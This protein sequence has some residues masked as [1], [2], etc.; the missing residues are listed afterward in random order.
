MTFKLGTFEAAARRFAGFVTGD[1]TVDL[2]AA[3][4][5]FAESSYGRQGRLTDATSVL[6]LLQDWDRNFAA[7]QRFAEFVGSEGFASSR[8]KG[9]VHSVEGLKVLPPVIRP[10]KMLYAAANY[11]EHVAGMR[12]TFRGGLPAVEPDKDYQGDKAKS[13]PYLFLKAGTCLA[14]PYDNIVLPAGSDK[15][16]WEAELA[17]VIGRPG[18]HIP[19]AKALDHVAGYMTTNDV[20]CRSRTWRADRPGLR[21]D[22]LG[23]KSYDTFAPMGPFLVPRAFVPDHTKLRIQ[24]LVNGISKQDGVSGDMVFGVEEQIEYASHMLTLEAGDVFATGTPAGTGQERL[25]YL[26]PGDVV[27]TEV[28]GLGRQ[29]NAVVAETAEYRQGQSASY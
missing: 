29:R 11:R 2:G 23:G 28:E 21:S 17:V 9:A 20:S 1:R 10:P 8:L 14:G 12:K 27:E 4:S 7:L 22:W 24:C 16:D 26:K 5:A 13:E 15:I 25:E 19:A 3:H 6:G 18:R